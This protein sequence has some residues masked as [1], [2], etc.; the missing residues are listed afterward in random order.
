MDFNKDADAFLADHPIPD[1]A[2]EDCPELV[3]KLETQLTEVSGR[4]RNGVTTRE[5]GNN[6]IEMLLMQDIMESLVGSLS[7]NDNQVEGRLKRLAA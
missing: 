1:F 5:D 2:R 6:E 7:A 4:I 3:A